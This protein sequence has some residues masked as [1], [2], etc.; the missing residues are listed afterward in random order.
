MGCVRNRME[1]GKWSC[2]EVTL[3][4]F[5]YEINSSHADDSFVY[6]IVCTA[7]LC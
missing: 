4:R 2:R 6:G 1:G 3:I 7:N 5:G